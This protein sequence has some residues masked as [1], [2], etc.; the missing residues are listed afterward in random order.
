MAR[1]DRVMGLA[2]L[3]ILAGIGLALLLGNRAGVTIEYAGPQGEASSTGRISLTFSEAMK[4]ETV[5]ARFHTEPEL[6]GAF[7]WDG[8]TLNFQPAQPLTP[9]LAVQVRLEA[10]AESESGRRVTGDTAF[11]FTVRQPEVAYLYPATGSPQN[12][13]IARPGDPA[14][15]RQVTFSPSGVFDFSVSPDGSQ[16]AFSAINSATGATD[17]M[18][19]DLASGGLTQ[20]TNC[21]SATCTGP[22]WRP[23]G[24]TIAYDRTERDDAAASQD[25]RSGATRVWLLDPTA[26]PATTRP[27]MS[28]L[29]ILGHSPQWSGDGRMIAFT[30]T[31][32]DAIIVTN[33]DTGQETSIPGGSGS[34]GALSPDG[35]QLAYP[36]IVVSEGTGVNSMLWLAD[37]AAG[38]RTQLTEA[39]GQVNDSRA[40]WRPDGGTLAV[41]RRNENAMRST[42]VVEMNPV[43]GETR[44]LT[45]DPRYSNMLFWWDAAG[46]ALVLQRFPEMDENGQPNLNGQPEIW[47]LDVNTGALTFVAN[48]GMLP[49]WVP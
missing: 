28:D 44:P 49:R 43:T 22:V 17:I 1:F 34:S 47:T 33:L 23:D 25:G 19:L 11:G 30:S 48:D 3:A 12:I 27:L 39:G 20:L 8:R 21:E 10:G 14:S 35:S 42:Q 41:A 40:Q 45:T 38:G 5:E 46:T 18:L 37:L 16:I 15:A 36:E 13:W 26:I 31:N 6:E 29:Q 4:H 2:V 9:G 32:L 7:S 24:K